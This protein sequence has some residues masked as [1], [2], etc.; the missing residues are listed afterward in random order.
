MELAQNTKRNQAEPFGLLGDPAWLSA[1]LAYLKDLDYF[2]QRQK[3]AK[4]P[5]A[6]EDSAEGAGGAAAAQQR[7]RPRPKAKGK[8]AN[9]Q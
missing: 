4:G 1:N 5:G 2:E 8:G 3:A 6:S 9:E 7:R